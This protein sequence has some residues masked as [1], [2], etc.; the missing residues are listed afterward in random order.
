VYLITG[1]LG[2]LGFHLAEALARDFKASLVLLGRRKLPPRRRWDA[3]LA[4]NDGAR[5]AVADRVRRI[6][7]LEA[8]GGKVMYRAPDLRDPTAMEAALEAA[9]ARFGPLH[10][11]IHGAGNVDP[12]AFQ[13]IDGIQPDTVA[14]H[15]SSKAEGLLGLVRAMAN[16]RP[17]DF[18]LLV[19]SLSSV[20]GG[21]GFTSYTAANAFLDAYADARRLETGVPW[22]SV[23]WDAWDVDNPDS[24]LAISAAQGQD[25]FLRILDQQHLGRVA[26]SVTPLQPRLDRWT[27]L[28]SLCGQTDEAAATPGTAET[29][30]A[31]GVPV[32]D[33][34]FEAGLEAELICLWRDVLGV[35]RVGLHDNFFS[36][37]GGNSLLA[38]QLV[39][40]VRSRY[41]VNLPL[42]VF[43]DA[44][45]VS[46]MSGVVVAL[47]LTGAEVQ[48]Q[49]EPSEIKRGKR[50]KA[51]ILS[52]GE[53]ELRP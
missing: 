4:S 41:G 7:Y 8:L 30:G 33:P 24:P 37:L 16:R 32:D 15:F 20:L 28:R 11:I 10:G 14:D 42:K 5:A 21:L 43:F 46:E 3:V 27:N 48:Q 22:I 26:V 1:G 2:R 12:A 36:Q 25:T 44:P 19:S 49:A 23:D 17:P 40:R 47:R 34:G 18:W 53:V 39:S 50:T 35:E 9:E 38:T 45:T 13:V 6:R 52:D 29:H 51:V 31:S